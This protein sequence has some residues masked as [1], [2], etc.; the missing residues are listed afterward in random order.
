MCHML[1]CINEDV[2]NTLHVYQITY[3][4]T[5]ITKFIFET[6]HMLMR[7]SKLTAS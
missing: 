5:E 2:K 1:N 6:K 7:I 4:L 3:Y